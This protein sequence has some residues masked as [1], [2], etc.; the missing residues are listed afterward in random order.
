MYTELLVPYA[1]RQPLLIGPLCIS[2]QSI[3]RLDGN[4]LTG[5]LTGDAM[6]CIA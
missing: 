4:E 6:F 1:G 3:K 2:A 5:W